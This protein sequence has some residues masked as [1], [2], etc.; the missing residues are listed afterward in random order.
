MQHTNRTDHTINL[1]AVCLSIQLC[2][3]KSNAMICHMLSEWLAGH[4]VSGTTALHSALIESSA[5]VFYLLAF[6]L[7]LWLFFSLGK[8]STATLHLSPTLPLRPFYTLSFSAALILISLT[9]L[10]HLSHL[11]PQLPAAAISIPQET[12]PLFFCFLRSVILPAFVAE[13][14]LRGFVL[15]ELLPWGRTFAI[16]FSAGSARCSP[17]I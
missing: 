10:G 1:L 4:G 6:L 7:P 12:V 2:I 15:Q 11:I 17:T 16:F 13:L 3:Y 5:L 9:A 14:F 8:T